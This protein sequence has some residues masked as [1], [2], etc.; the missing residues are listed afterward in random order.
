MSNT[1]LHKLDHEGREVI[2][3]PFNDFQLSEQIDYYVDS[4]SSNNISVQRDWCWTKIEWINQNSEELVFR[5]VCNID[6]HVNSFERFLA[7][8]TIPANTKYRFIIESYSKIYPITDWEFGKN[9]RDE[10]NV[11]LPEAIVSSEFIHKIILEVRSSQHGTLMIS[12][13]RTF[14]IRVANHSIE[15]NR[16]ELG[17]I[18]PSR[19]RLAG[20]KF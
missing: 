8:I 2:I 17:S 5:F 13:L 19:E 12:W 9:T 11:P 15:K 14:Y 7:A 1:F 20:Y 18:S 16:K 4:S 3:A 10:C 6:C